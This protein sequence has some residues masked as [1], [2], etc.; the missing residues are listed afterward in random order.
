VL[1]PGGSVKDR[2]AA[3][4]V[5]EARRSGKLEPGKILLHAT[6]GNTGIAY[7]MLGA[8]L[9]QVKLEI[10]NLESTI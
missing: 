3:N 5:T 4:I 2:A 10:C 1:H 9:V 6:S 8:A 7:A